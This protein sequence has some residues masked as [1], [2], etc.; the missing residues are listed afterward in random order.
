MSLANEIEPHRLQFRGFNMYKQLLVV[1]F[2]IR[3]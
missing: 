1:E 3:K 2:E